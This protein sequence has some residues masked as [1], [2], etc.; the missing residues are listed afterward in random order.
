MEEP[1]GNEW[2]FHHAGL[3]V[4]DLDAALKAC[5]KLGFPPGAKLTGPADTQDRVLMQFVRL[6]D[7]EVEFFQPVS[8]QNI[9]SEFLERHGEGLHHLAFEVKDLETETTKLAEAGMK[10]FLNFTGPSGNK[11][12]FFDPGSLGGTVIELIQ[13]A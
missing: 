2:K 1:M 10:P 12:G 4:K 5:G 8:G 3:V 7:C 9:I 6:G 13:R 11:I